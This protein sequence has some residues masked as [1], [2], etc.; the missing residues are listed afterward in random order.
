[1]IKQQKEHSL[2]TTD[3]LNIYLQFFPQAFYV[4]YYQMFGM[5]GK[6]I[7]KE[8]KQQSAAMSCECVHL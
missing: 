6:I 1:M 7:K 5:L 3:V 2:C 4:K 8:P